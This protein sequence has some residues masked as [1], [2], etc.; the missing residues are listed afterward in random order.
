MR[1]F[2]FTRQSTARF[3]CV[4]LILAAT[5]DALAAKKSKTKRK[6]KPTASAINT[7]YVFN[8]PYASAPAALVALEQ[9]TDIHAHETLPQGW[10][11]QENWK[12]FNERSIGKPGLIEW[13]FT[14][15]SHA[16]HPAVVKRYFDVGSADHIYIDT[17]IKCSGE[18]TACH[19][20]S[21]VVEQA[22]W[23]IKK[24]NERNFV[25]EGEFLWKDTPSAQPVSTND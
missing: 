24:T 15:P 14:Q 12:I 4:L 6:T 10:E 22:N 7:K 20:L 16:A 13:A 19:D 5:S 1:S 8:I 18:A 3:I 17:A 25:K 23:R 21:R 2:L 11:T 9:R